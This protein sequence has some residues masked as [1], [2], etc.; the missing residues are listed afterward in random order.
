MSDV[1][2]KVREFVIMV[3]DMKSMHNITGNQTLLIKFL[4]INNKITCIQ[5]R[6][7]TKSV[8]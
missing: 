8:M 1:P 6:N 2:I 5:L 4:S 7:G 3:S